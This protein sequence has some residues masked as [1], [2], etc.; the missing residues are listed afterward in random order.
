[1]RTCDSQGA[2]RKNEEMF[3][4]NCKAVSAKEKMQGLGERRIG[5]QRES[6]R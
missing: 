4:V 5:W 2:G 1:M 6:E 3:G